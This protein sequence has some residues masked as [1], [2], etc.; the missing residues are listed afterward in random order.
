MN[1]T[2]FSKPICSLLFKLLLCINVPVNFWRIWHFS[3][4]VPVYSVC[5]RWILAPSNMKG[6][7][8]PLCCRAGGWN[9]KKGGA[10]QWHD[11]GE[12]FHC[13]SVSLAWGCATGNIRCSQSFLLCAAA[14][15]ENHTFR[16]FMSQRFSPIDVSFPP[17]HLSSHNTWH[18][19]TGEEHLLDANTA[20]ASIKGSNRR[21]PNKNR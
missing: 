8:L 12:S 5:F 19:K 13:H 3:E 17:T 20:Q 1:I 4:Q 11:C 15:Q 18:S 2:Y 21:S 9:K 6:T 7:H 16:V 10:E 14:F